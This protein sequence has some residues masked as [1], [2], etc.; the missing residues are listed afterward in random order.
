MN[1]KYELL[2]E[3]TKLEYEKEVERFVRIEDKANKLLT[4]TSIFIV[5]F[6]TIAANSTVTELYSN[7]HLTFKTFYWLLII[8]YVISNIICL[9]FTLKCLRLITIQNMP[10]GK[11]TFDKI[12]QYSDNRSYFYIAKAYSTYVNQNMVTNLIKTKYYSVSY[13]A[14]FCAKILFVIYLLMLG[15]MILTATDENCSKEQLTALL[16]KNSIK[17]EIKLNYSDCKSGK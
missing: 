16:E 15:G 10:I 13:Y 12:Q 9:I 5:A 11:D 14:L 7:S 6:T 17:H 2:Y 4:L 3:V 1:P 8:L